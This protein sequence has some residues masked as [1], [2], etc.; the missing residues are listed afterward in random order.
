MA[1]AAPV[2]TTNPELE[3]VLSDL[4]QTVAWRVICLIDEGFSL[5]Q[6]LR[7]CQRNDVVHDAHNLLQRM[8][9]SLVVEE[10][11]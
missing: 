7:L 11:T 6:T 5:E 1:T 9:H 4:E 8:P 10:L 2:E 3:R